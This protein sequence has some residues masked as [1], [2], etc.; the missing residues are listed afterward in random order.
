MFKTNLPPLIIRLAGLVQLS[1]AASSLAIPKLLGWRADVARLKP[2]T[3]RVFWTYSGYILA[4]NIS[5]GLL[6]T[7]MPEQL[8]AHT[9]LA[10]AVSGFIAI[11]WL[12]RLII[13]F[14]VFDRVEVGPAPLFRVAR[15]MYVTAFASL[16]LIYSLTALS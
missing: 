16:A 2:L 10:I 15:L 13:Q 4:T 9:P 6:S 1:I 7:L 12:S 11:Y 14:A 8:A 5:L 3:A